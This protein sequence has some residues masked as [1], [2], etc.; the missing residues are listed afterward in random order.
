MKHLFLTLTLAVFL[1]SSCANDSQDDL[2]ETTPLPNVVTYN[3]DI[4]TIID[5]NCISCHGSSPSQN[6]PMSLTTFSQVSNYI[7]GI[8]DRINRLGAGKM[9]VNGTLS[10]N[11]KNLIQKWKDDG[12]LEN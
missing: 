8:I 3:D 1:L 2:I 5:N 11:E 6:A 7:D 10:T 12:L 9:P 4:K